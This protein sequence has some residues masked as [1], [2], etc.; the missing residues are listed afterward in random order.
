[1]QRDGVVDRGLDGPASLAGVLGIAGD[2][3]E[4][5]VVAQRRDQQVE[6]PGADHRALAPGVEDVDDVL[7]QVDL[8]EQL[9][10]LGVGLHDGVLDAV[11]DH[12]GEV[13]GAGAGA[14]VH[15]AGLTGRLEGVE[16]RLDHGDRV[17][18]ASA[19][20][21]VAVL[22]PPDASG[23]AAVDEADAAL[24]QQRGM[25]LVVGPPGV[26]AVDD[27]VALGQQLGELADRGPGRVAGGHHH[28]RRRRPGCGR[29]PRPCAPPR[30]GG[31]ACCRPSCRVRPARSACL[32]LRPRS[33]PSTVVS[34]AE[35]PARLRLSRP[36]S[37]V[38]G[39]GQP[40]RRRGISR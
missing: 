4:V 30:A 15:E 28:P 40:S 27:D 24:G 13:A 33:W 5:L 36:G 12:L 6:Q 3:V 23:D 38:I 37:A 2:L 9:E 10:A 22:Q 19:H 34:R 16:G 7:D 25:L 18:R 39:R 20:Q 11:V 21:C 1:M 31:C 14:G 8:L 35:G 17:V 29:S 32:L 26:A